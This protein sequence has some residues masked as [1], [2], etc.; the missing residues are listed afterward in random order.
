MKHPRDPSAAVLVVDDEALLRMLASDVLEE[1]G[2][3]VVEAASADAAL[4]AL[5]SHPEIR[6][7]FTDVDMP[8]SL[9]GLGLARVVQERWPGIGVLVVSGKVRPRPCDLPP[10]GHFVSK[11]YRP[12]DV[13]RHVQSLIQTA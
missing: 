9:D 1:A 6:V 3:E 5:Q 12:E 13:V 10:G 4:V 2:F 11:P 8:G 7:V